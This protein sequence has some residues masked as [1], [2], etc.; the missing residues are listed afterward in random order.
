MEAFTLTVGDD[1]KFGKQRQGNFDLLASMGKQA[2]MDV[3]S[4]AS[5]RQLNARVSSTLI[6]D[7]LASG[8]LASA[9]IMLGHDYAISGRVIH[10]WKRGRELGFRT[11]NIALKRQVCPVNGVFAVQATIAGKQI[12]GVANAWAPRGSRL[13]LQLTGIEF[14]FKHMS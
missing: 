7:A 14:L 13:S 12:F 4:T 11:A 5:F 10:G 3:K 1:F 8:D 2:G 6:R 9:K